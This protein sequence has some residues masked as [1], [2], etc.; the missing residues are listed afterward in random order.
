[1]HT[2]LGCFLA[3]LLITSPVLAGEGH[4][5]AKGRGHDHAKGH[6]HGHA[7]GH[8][9]GAAKALGAVLPPYLRIQRA[10][11]SDKTDGIAPAATKLVA[12]ARKHHLAQVAEHAA[13]LDGKSIEADRAAFRALSKA[14]ARIVISHPPARAAY[15]VFDCAQAPGIWVQQSKTPLNPYQGG[16]LRGCGKPVSA[17]EG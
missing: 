8:A 9:H 14:V 1:M 10:L 12:T 17:I 16:K 15:H 13:K 3:V 4:D 2:A 7:E 11:A 5:H 6:A